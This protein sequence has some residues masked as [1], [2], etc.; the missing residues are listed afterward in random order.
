MRIETTHQTFYGLP[1]SKLPFS[2]PCLVDDE[3]VGRQRL[4][5]ALLELPLFKCP[6]PLAPCYVTAMCYPLVG[7]SEWPDSCCFSW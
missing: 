6:M 5:L 3:G 2:I 1:A 7:H 4:T